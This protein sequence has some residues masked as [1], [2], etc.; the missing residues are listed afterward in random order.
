M[1]KLK[2]TISALTFAT[3]LLSTVSTIQPLAEEVQKPLT[4]NKQVPLSS[5]F[6][7]NPNL[8]VDEDTKEVQNWRYLN[9]MNHSK[10]IFEDKNAEG[11][12]TLEQDNALHSLKSSEHGFELKTKRISDEGRSSTTVYQDVTDLTPGK[13]YTFNLSAITFEDNVTITIYHPGEKFGETSTNLELQKG[14]AIPVNIRFKAT[15]NPS[16]IS[17]V[18]QAP[19]TSGKETQVIYSDLSIVDSGDSALIAAQQAV[20]A[21]FIDDKQKEII[22]GLPQEKIDKATKLV[23]Q[24]SNTGEKFKLEDL[25]SKAQKMFQ[26]Q[27]AF[28]PLFENPLQPG[29]EFSKIKPDLTPNDIFKA[30][31]VVLSSTYVHDY[32]PYI[33]LARELWVDVH[34]DIGIRQTVESLFSD[35][36]FTQLAPETTLETIYDFKYYI[37]H[38][39]DQL[40]AE[41]LQE[42]IDKAQ[43]LAETI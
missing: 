41:K 43:E 20:Q 34:G 35:K 7:K 27:Q 38:V 22:M 37:Q 9:G 3:L 1:K 23:E 16:F 15:E 26:S 32:R 40:E 31:M 24:L 42:L 10:L 36:T 18:Q 19:N 5:N 2:K 17:I 39:K 30:H 13:V 14:E 21:L 8:Y 29:A 12:Y 33:N 28:L 4:V 6:L 11:F 25:I